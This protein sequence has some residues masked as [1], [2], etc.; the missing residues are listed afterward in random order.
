VT[1]GLWVVLLAA[2]CTALVAAGLTPEQELIEW[3]RQSGGTVSS[4]TELGALQGLCCKAHDSRR[5]AAWTTL[6]A[7]SPSPHACTP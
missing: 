5:R 3:I 7:W 6:L 4:P 1:A 2:T